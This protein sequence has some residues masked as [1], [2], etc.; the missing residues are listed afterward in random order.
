M[1]I[2]ISPR[3]VYRP[4]AH[5]Q[6]KNIPSCPAKPCVR[7]QAVP[8]PL[9]DRDRRQAAQEEAAREA[10]RMAEEMT[11]ERVNAI[12]SSIQQQLQQ[13]DQQ[14]QQRDETIK[15]QQEQQ[16]QFKDQNKR[17]AMELQRLTRLIADLESAAKERMHTDL[18]VEFSSTGKRFTWKKTS[19]NTV[20]L[21]GNELSWWVAKDEVYTC[22]L[23]TSVGIVFPCRSHKNAV[24]VEAK[25]QQIFLRLFF[26]SAE[27]ATTRLRCLED[28]RQ[29]PGTQGVGKWVEREGGGERGRVSN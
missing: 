4:H 3:L 25:S 24:K 28:A 7:V 19:G 16:E 14:L 15:R 20:R 29:V 13:R 1:L 18:C 5:A 26:G 22:V 21:R 6:H 2:L 27:T 8:V 10:Q 12:Q 9:T 17:H 23:F 11:T